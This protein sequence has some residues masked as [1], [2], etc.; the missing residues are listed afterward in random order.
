MLK[1]SFTIAWRYLSRNKVYSGINIA[2][3]ALGFAAFWLIALFVADELSYDRYH[4]KAGRIYRLVSHGRW[5]GGGF[6]ITGTS[7]Q[8]GGMLKAAFPEVEQTVRIDPEG[9]GQITRGD[10][11][12]KV[13]EIMMTDPGFFAVFTHHFLAGDSRTALQKPQ[14]IVLTRDLAEQLFGNAEA[15]LNQTVYFENKYPNQVTGVIDNVPGNSHFTFRAL[16]SLPKE[17]TADLGN[18]S[19]YTYILLSDKADGR[20]FAAKLPAFVKKQLGEVTAE[21]KYWLEAQP[22][23]SIH[24]NSHLSYELGTNRSSTFIYVI[25][26]VGLL[27]LLIAFINYANITTARAS[28]RLREVAVRKVIGSERRHLI[29]L[30][31]VESLL[32]VLIAVAVSALIVVLFMPVFNLITAKEL[33]IWRF[34][35]VPSLLVLLVFSMLTSVIGGLYPALF[36]SGFR[37]IPA[38]KNQMGDQHFSGLF[39]RSLVVFQFVVT[40]VMIAVSIVIYSQL[41]FMQNKDLGFNKQQVLTFHLDKQEL[42]AKLAGLRSVLMQNPEVQAVASAGNPIG[43]NNIG[44]LDYSVERNDAMDQA[45]PNLGFGLTIDEDFIPAMQMRLAAGRNFSRET[46]TDSS[47]SVIINEAL[48]RK[49]GWKDAI[50][51]R[52]SFGPAKPVQVIGVVRDFHLYSLQHK[53]EPMIFQLPRK[54][55][56]KDNVYVRIGRRDVRKTL[57]FIEQTFRRFDSESPFDYHFIDQNFKQQY[58]AEEKQ[59]EVLLLFTGLTIGIACLGLFA[60]ITFTTEQRVKEIGIRK[61]LGATTAG[62][63]RLLSADLIRLVCIALL[64]A[65][66]LAWLAMHRWLD[67]FAY[68]IGISWWMFAAA[69]LLAVALAVFTLSFQAIRAALANPVKSL[70]SE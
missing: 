32:L 52:I 55:N 41:H 22:L 50:G 24:L 63:V 46:P 25:G 5:D 14:S 53:I 19:T 68:R 21:M 36:L 51:K 61:V 33:E 27:V 58:Q 40:V 44:M 42:R 11:R 30:F 8:L 17:Y 9:G 12:I 34:G 28:V 23:T 2:G 67:G 13:D 70:R 31:L 7:A 62:L 66:P 65:T 38:L 48:A 59:G 45:H 60:L 47:E 37:T 3:L 56:D 16:R 6:D 20:Q 1:S 54:V 69:G 29:R 64:I 15:A 10:K 49:A 18:F 4:E 43:N 39:R 57:A 35:I 26:G